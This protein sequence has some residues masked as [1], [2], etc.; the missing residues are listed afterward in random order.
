VLGLNTSKATKLAVRGALDCER[1][2]SSV[3]FLSG[4]KLGESSA[5]WKQYQPQRMAR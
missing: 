3:N 1:N 2:G 4:P 5:V